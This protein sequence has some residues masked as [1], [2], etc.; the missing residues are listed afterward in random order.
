[1]P[2]ALGFSHKGPD[3]RFVAVH[4]PL[5]NPPLPGLEEGLGA[6][7]LGG[8]GWYRIR[9]LVSNRLDLPGDELVRWYR[10]R[11]GKGEAVHIVLKDGP[12]GRAAAVG[13]LRGERGLVGARGAGLQPARGVQDAGAGRPGRASA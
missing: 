11:C 4:E 2:N 9:G 1:M 8:G 3:Y 7:A 6:V 5:R 13:A 12:G 10:A